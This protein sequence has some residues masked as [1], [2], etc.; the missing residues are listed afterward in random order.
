[1]HGWVRIVGN[2][3]ISPAGIRFIRRGFLFGGVFLLGFGPATAQR[4][5]AA[6]G[7]TVN[8]TSS[9]APEPPTPTI[10]EMVG[11]TIPIVKGPSKFEQKATEAPAYVTVVT[12]NEIKQYGHRTLADVLLSVNGMHVSYD[13]NYSYLGVRGFNLGDPNNFNSRVLLLVDGHRMNNGLSDSAYVGTEFI[14][15]VD[16]ID[17]VEVIRGPGSVLYGNNAF[18]G[19]INVITRN[20]R[21]LKGPEVSGEVASYDTF[22]G[23]LS[24]GNQW[25]NGL[26][27]LLSGSLY[28]SEGPDE[29]V[30]RLDDDHFG[31]FFGSLGYH[32]FTLQGAFIS[33]DKGN[34]T[35]Q[36]GAVTNDSRFQTLDER[37]YVNFKFAHDFTN[38]MELMA[39][40]HYDRYDFHLD[41]PLPTP[42]STTLYQQKQVGE[43]WGAELQ[44]TKRLEQGHTFILGGEYRDDF[45][46][47]REILI[48]ASPSRT[49]QRSTDNY[50]VFLQ[51]DVA[52]RT[53]LHL[54]AGARYDQYG[55]FD[56]AF[57]PRVAVIYS[58]V[59]ESTFKA[60]YGTAF[61]VPTFREQILAYPAT[62]LAPEDIT[63]YELVY[64]QGIGKH[65]RSTVAGFY[66]QI[67]D[68][69]IHES[70]QFQNLDAEAKGVTVALG[71]VWTKGP[72]GGISYT[73]Q[74]VEDRATGRRLPDAPQ[75]L[76]KLNL[77]VPLYRDKVFAGVEFQYTSE[78]KTIRTVIANGQVTT[79]S[80]S[81]AEGFGIVN[82]TLFSQN[83]VK[84]LE[85]SATV[86]NLLD[87]QYGDPASPQHFQDIIPQDGRTFRVKLTYR[88]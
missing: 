43:W 23:R 67:N 28:D 75:H 51:G 31:S 68:L 61:R 25:S 11:W 29:G 78:R 73:F 34:P 41:L 8:F 16:L 9:P 15:D 58:P 62:E 36:F 42:P 1:M 54:N 50:G 7:N 3:W 38:V 46:Q 49:D 40:V 44:L 52:L 88:F 48:P 4:L 86:Y 19:V 76:G 77:S 66:N 56:P 12:S 35:A 18:L 64:E 74:D 22:K 72:R 26:E 21:Q 70:G 17:R 65:L 33:R 84:G 24:Y 69:I 32:D 14:L 37:S 82:L 6:E 2:R 87:K 10:E 60:I 13:R 30:Q 63:T 71:G 45:R 5:A 59:L 79:V 80:G 47:E 83:L 85:L 55:D 39:Q 27:L 81:D 57:S 53:N 20:G